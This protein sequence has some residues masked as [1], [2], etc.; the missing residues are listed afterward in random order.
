[1]S[2]RLEIRPVELSEASLL[3]DIYAPYVLETAISFEMEPPSVSDF[4]RRIEQ[5]TAD[6]PWLVA[7][8]D[9][10]VVGYAYAGPHRTRAA[11]Q[12]SVETSVYVAQESHGRQIG[13]TL[14]WRLLS[15]L[16]RREY[17]N[18]YAGITLPNAA[19]VALHNK[20]GFEQI[21]V[22]PQ[23]GFK[24]DCWHDVAWFHRPIDLP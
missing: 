3:V 6:Y 23:V 10:T 12:Y 24:F 14:Y 5:L 21:G 20:M 13:F 2:D 15:E 4:T 11:Y 8:L 9:S 17:R 16:S 18:A 22:F 7:T 19:S 1:M